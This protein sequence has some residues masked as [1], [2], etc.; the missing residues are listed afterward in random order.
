MAPFASTLSTTTRSWTAWGIPLAAAALVMAISPGESYTVTPAPAPTLGNYP[1]TTINLSAS[2][3]ITPDAPPTL[4]PRLGVSSYPHFS[5]TFA[6]DPTTGVIRVTNASVARRSTV[7]VKAF[8]SSSVATKLHAHSRSRRSVH[9]PFIFQ[10][11]RRFR[12]RLSPTSIA[13]GDFNGD[14]RQDLA[15][16]NQASGSVSISLGDGA[17]GFAAVPVATVGPQSFRTRG[18]RF[19]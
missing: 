9:R 4:A 16:A 13:V 10:R 12:C 11:R 5:G 15:T 2:A 6:A 7:A 3:T 18:R 17:G 1:N 19:Q 14:G 8:G